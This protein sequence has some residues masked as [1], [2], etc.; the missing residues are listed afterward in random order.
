MA[1]G[2]G[3]DANGSS[4]GK[5]IMETLGGNSTWPRH[6][7]PSAQRAPQHAAWQ[8]SRSAVRGEATPQF[9]RPQFEPRSVRPRQGRQLWPLIADDFF[10]VAQDDRAK[11]LIHR[12]IAKVGLSA[13]ILAELVLAGYVMI[14]DGRL[15]LLMS[16]QPIDSLAR[17]VAFEIGEQHDPLSVRDWL[18]A[19]STVELRGADIFDRVGARLVTAGKAQLEKYGLRRNKVRYRPRDANVS[20]WAWAH[21][22]RALHRG[23]NLGHEDVVLA[24]LM[25]ACDLH[26]RVLIGDTL[27]L[28]ADIRARIKAVPQP[29]QD[30]LRHAEGAI[31]SAITTSA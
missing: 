26:G 7:E 17:H 8:R 25:L 22:S 1:V 6:N 18:A 28:E 20:G 13:A 2:Y 12:E 9:P 24:G 11:P 4:Y 16:D 23:E 15:D 10:L 19:L 31:G 27:G 21:V 14:V 5:A 29:V 3:F 30:L